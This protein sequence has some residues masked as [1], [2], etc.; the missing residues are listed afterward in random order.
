M[1]KKIT[2][3]LKLQI[4]AGKANPAPPLGPALGGA[5]VNIG[6]FVQD[7]NAKTAQM[8]GVVSI[9]MNVYDDRSF[10]YII[11]TPPVTGLILKAAG[12]EAGSGKNAQKRAGSN[13]EHKILVFIYAQVFLHEVTGLHLQGPGHSFNVGLIK[14]RT[15]CLA[16]IRTRETVHLFEHVVVGLMK[17]IIDSSGIFFLQPKKKFFVFSGLL[18]GPFVMTCQVHGG[19]TT[20]LRLSWTNW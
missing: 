2:K 6:A 9:V 19:C 8:Q 7:F 1:A 12:V 5:G 11:K 17:G 15:G 18:P 20:H 3:T 4:A 16:A 14:D 13:L 10:D